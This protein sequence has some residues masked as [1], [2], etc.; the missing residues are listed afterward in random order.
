[1]EMDLHS[2]LDEE[3]VAQKGSVIWVRATQAPSRQISNISVARVVSV[4]SSMAGT[5]LLRGDSKP[6]IFLSLQYNLILMEATVI[7]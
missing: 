2:K 3:M 7:Q 6:F 1:M 5:D 4:Y